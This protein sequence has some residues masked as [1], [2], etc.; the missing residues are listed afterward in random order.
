[1]RIEDVQSYKDLEAFVKLELARQTTKRQIVEIELPPRLFFNLWKLIQFTIKYEPK[2]RYATT[3][4]E[5]EC[6]KM[7]VKINKVFTI[8]KR[9]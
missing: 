8:I 5:P 4:I 1:M 2:E 3:E 9:V 6:K 7:Q